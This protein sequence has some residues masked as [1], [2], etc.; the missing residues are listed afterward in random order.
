MIVTI[1]NIDSANAILSVKIEKTDYQEK[2]EKSLRNFRQKANIPG[3]RKGMT[4]MGMIKKMYE[5]SVVAE[6]INKLVSEG[7]YGYI[8]ENKVN[9][10]GEPLPN[11]TLQKPV[12]F[13]KDQEFEFLFDLGMA[14]TIKIALSKKDKADYYNVEVSEEMIQKQS[15]AF[16]DRAGKHIQVETIEA[17]DMIKG[18]LVELD[19][20]GVAKEEGISTP[21]S[22]MIPSY[23]KNETETE[24]FVGAA[25]GAT[26]IFNPFDACGGNEFEMAHILK[27]DKAEAKDVKS[28]FS[29][30]ITEITRHITAELSQ[31]VFDSAFGEGTVS[32]EAEYF[33]KIKESLQA[34]MKPE[35][36]YKFWLDIRPLLEA[37]AGEIAFPIDFLKRWLV[38]SGENRT[39]E[40]VE[41]ELPA[42]IKELTW[43]LIK[44]NL[45]KDNEVKV[46][47]ADLMEI[48]K[49][50][51]RAQFASYGM[52]E[53]PADMLE[54]YS[55]DMLKDEKS[56]RNLIERAV[57]DKVRDAVKAQISLNEKAISQE[58]FYKLFEAQA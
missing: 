2:V 32:T 14:P 1:N 53:V 27:V 45:A 50:T 57:E 5:K 39:V 38:A 8:Q 26:V 35:S 7:L 37:K 31:E 41:E 55:A 48:A 58:D 25:K 4:P 15:K 42:M 40:S 10:L 52:M 43:H 47:Q 11:V 20:A 13:E 19:E 34:Q 28:N 23:F 36:D 22:A 21:D 49:A 46:E 12:D 30:T 6:E 9:I 44:E 56:R 3:F 33:A 29:Y 51:T 17:K 18:I 16:T 54:K 24:K